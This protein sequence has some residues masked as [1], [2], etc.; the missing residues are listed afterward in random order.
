M[1]QDRSEKSGNDTNDHSMRSYDNM[2]TSINQHH[3]QDGAKSTNNNDYTDGCRYTVV[4][5]A[6]TLTTTQDFNV[7]R[8][9][10]YQ[11][12]IGTRLIAD[13]IHLPETIC[14]VK[15][16]TQSLLKIRIGCNHEDIPTWWASWRMFIVPRGLDNTT[17]EELQYLL[18]RIDKHISDDTEQN[19]DEDSSN[20]SDS[21]SDSCSVPQSTQNDNHGCDIDF[22]RH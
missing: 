21:C 7:F 22:R 3:D 18:D 14:R 15:R 12:W 19:E 20:S 9:T 4:G 2:I 5:T 11:T 17:W 13:E 6:A 8:D 16:D 1:A 10:I